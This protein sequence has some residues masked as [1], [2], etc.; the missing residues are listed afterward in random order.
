M[1]LL[2]MYFITSDQF[3]LRIIYSC[4]QAYKIHTNIKFIIVNLLDVKNIIR[5]FIFV[6]EHYIIY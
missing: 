2:V 6:S 1:K 4:F 5:F 3:I